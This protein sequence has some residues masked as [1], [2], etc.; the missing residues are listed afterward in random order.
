M[1]TYKVDKIVR[2]VDG[3][4]VDITIDL[5]FNIHYDARVRMYGINAPESRTRDLEEKKRGLAAKA[6]LAQLLQGEEVTITTSKD[7]TGKFGRL[8]GEFFVKG[9][10]IN[11]QLIKEGHG[12]PYFGGKR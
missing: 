10:N 8:L 7:K 12:V 4:T 6:R 1:Y 3:D 5:G 2:V 9:V 11:E